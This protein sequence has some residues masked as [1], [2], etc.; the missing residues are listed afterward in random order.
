VIVCVD[1]AVKKLEALGHKATDIK[2]I[3]ITNQ[4]ETALVWSKST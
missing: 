3:G 1:E 4:R 2:A